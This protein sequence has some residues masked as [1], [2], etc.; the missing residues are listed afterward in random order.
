MI[1][2]KGKYKGVIENTTEII[3]FDTITEVNGEVV[4]TRFL[5]IEL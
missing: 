5:S 2:K 1:S 3:C 4:Y